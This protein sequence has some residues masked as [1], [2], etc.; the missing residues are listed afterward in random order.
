MAKNLYDEIRRR[1]DPE[2]AD[3]LTPK[4]FIP[5]L[6]GCLVPGVF[7]T[8]FVLLRSN[9]ALMDFIVFQVTT[10][11]K[12]VISAVCSL[13]PF[14]VAEIIWT[15]G[16]IAAVEFIVRTVWLLVKRK[17]KLLRL[18]QRFLAGLAAALVIYSCYTIMWGVNYYA[19]SFQSRSG[20][21]ARGC[22]AEELH[23]LTAKFAQSCNELSGTVPRDDSGLTQFKNSDIFPGSAKLYAGIQEEFDCL[24]GMLHDPRPM[25]FS[26]VLGMMGFTGFYFPM[27]AESIVSVDQA[28]CLIPA[29]ILHELAH[30]RN[31]A[32]EDAANF[33]AIVAGERCGDQRFQYS[34][35]LLAYIHLSNALYKADQSLWKEVDATL[36]AQVTAD[37]ESNNS[38]WK[39]RE[40]PIKTVSEGIYDGYLKSNGQTQGMKS[41]GECVDLLAAYYLG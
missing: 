2:A 35:S 9:T 18:L 21:T 14:N 1:T 39:K 31:V 36:N 12:G 7:L 22:T 41:Y 19:G 40:T 29:T 16:V 15:V 13:L 38:Y 3:R 24:Q 37:L 5:P 6:I 25:F 27:T 10:P 23:Q 32:E 4:S 28:D 20:I 30:Q 26:K 11:I 17:Q 8:L 34:T 33:V